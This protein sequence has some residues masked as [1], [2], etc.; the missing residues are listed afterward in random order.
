MQ[1]LQTRAMLGMLLLAHGVVPK[2]VIAQTLPGR[3]K[4]TW[5]APAECSSDEAV[6]REIQR[7]L[8]GPPSRAANAR[9]EVEQLGPQRWR[10]RLTTE[11][12]SVTGE[13]DLE[14]DSCDGLVAATALIL[15][16]SI[17]PQRAAGAGLAPDGA[18]PEVSRL[19]PA[20][21]AP[22]PTAGL[23]VPSSA[24]SFSQSSSPPPPNPSQRLLRG[25]LAVDA[26]SDLGTL[27]AVGLAGRVTLG[28][29]VG[30]IR[31]EGSFADWL[32]QDVTAPSPLSAQGATLHP[33]EGALRGCFRWIPSRRFELD[34]CVGGG[35]TY[36]TSNGFLETIKT[37]TGETAKATT[38]GSVYGEAL[39]VLTLGGPFALRG[40]LGFV[41][42]LA[43]PE[44][45]IQE[46]GKSS[47]AVFLSQ[48]SFISGR[49]SLGLEAH[50]P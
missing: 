21:L 27:P 29:L 24:P 49:A 25:V 7:I 50:F 1:R 3:L 14:A 16:W 15:A 13:R 48:A 26:V 11:V 28:A 34:P 19:Q 8:G 4:L 40:A 38:W 5:N 45:D 30:P 47:A 46:Q 23:V 6:Q 2:T 10:E 31:L 20:A 39:G 9:A 22:P 43:R 36:V 42:P 18:Q 37:F 41:V 33:L 32:S 12:D 17:D 35:L 44:F